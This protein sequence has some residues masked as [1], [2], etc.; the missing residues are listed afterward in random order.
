MAFRRR[1]RGALGP[2][3]TV[4]HYITFGDFKGMNTQSDRHALPE[5]T[6]AWL[7]NVQPI[8]PN[9]LAVVPGPAPTLATL[10]GETITRQFFAP[11]N[12]K[13]YEIDICASGNA[14]AVD[15]NNGSINKFVNFGS[16][17]A[18]ADVTVWNS[19]R[20]LIADP[21][22]GYA[23]WD[24]T[25]FARQ[26][27]V[28]PNLVLTAGGT[29]YTLGADVA[30]SGG[31]G[32]GATATAQTS[33]GIV[34]GLMLTGSGVGY[35][36]GDTLTVTITPHGGGG[37][38]GATGSAHPWPTITKPNSLAVFAGRVWLSNNRSITYTGTGAGAA[39][40]GVGYDD[41][42]SADASGTT[43]LLDP[44]LIQSITVL[45]A[46]NNYLFIFGDN[47]VKQIGNVSVS[48]SATNFTTITLSSDQGTIYPDTVIS[49]NRLVLF[50]NTVGVFAVFGTS[51]E[52]IS[53]DMDGIFAAID[54]TQFPC[55]AV[56]DINNIHCYT[57]LVRYVDP[58][59]NAPRSLILAFASKKWFTCS[60][61]DQLRF[62]HTAVLGGRTETFATS[63]S[64]VTQIIA[65]NTVNVLITIKTALSPHNIPYLQKNVV[66]V[67]T[68]QKANTTD[69]LILTIESEL[70]SQAINYS[71]APAII[72]LN[73][74]GQVVTWTNMLGQLV[75]FVKDGFRYFPS[76]AN[77]SGIYIGAT[78]SGSVR[79][80]SLN[81]I[82]IEF[83]EGPMFQAK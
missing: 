14:Y 61:G 78:I 44:D 46:L 43:T 81:T 17:N 40:G 32:S 83:Q 51:V 38:S 33:G 11:F 47:S 4:S 12:G 21:N 80:Y 28:S 25:V 55:A 68:A 22:I 36:P 2:Q 26:G 62:I 60:Q 71:L 29:G 74:L 67:A 31:S 16:L 64:D 5:N 48:G 20:I 50:A 19:Q 82:V 52:K 76:K 45:R 35:L 69:S 39:F 18:Q 49:Y 8:G 70:N 1:Q 13:N 34:V 10:P 56:N 9:N 57:L 37:G 79:Q 41:F 54:F 30:I 6:P 53:D 72:W 7:E 59:L 58:L 77:V 73:N 65:L 23:T 15:L 27:G 66:R 42:T 63:G 75:T 24:G 3:Q